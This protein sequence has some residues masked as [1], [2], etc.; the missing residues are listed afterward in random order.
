MK[1]SEL[2]KIPCLYLGPQLKGWRWWDS[3]RSVGKEAKHSGS[4]GYAAEKEH[5]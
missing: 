4:D 1:S 5:R 2:R 3:G